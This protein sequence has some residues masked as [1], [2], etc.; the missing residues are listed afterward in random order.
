MDND[1]NTDQIIPTQ[2]MLLQCKKEM[3]T[4]CFEGFSKNIMKDA[5]AGGIIVAGENFGCGSATVSYT[6]LTLPTSDLV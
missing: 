4:H 3:A 2:Y 6:H 5:Q 1:I